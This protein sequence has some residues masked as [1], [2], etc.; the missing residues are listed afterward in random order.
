MAHAVNY[1]GN[2]DPAI[3]VVTVVATAATSQGDFV[4]E[5]P[6]FGVALNDAA[7]GEDLLIDIV[8]H[9]RCIGNSTVAVAAAIGD[10]I[11]LNP[12]TGV[13]ATASATG[14]ALIG[15]TTEVKDSNNYF[16]FEKV[17]YTTVAA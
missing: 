13:Y 2:L 1:Q 4:I 15:Y 14:N 6:W 17:T 11:Y 3:E 9:K 10:A 16:E 8:A 7:I 12:S 5:G